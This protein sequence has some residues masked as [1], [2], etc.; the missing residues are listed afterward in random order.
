MKVQ[1][2]LK[3][4]ENLYL[5]QGYSDIH[6]RKYVIFPEYSIYMEINSC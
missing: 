6:E 2:L 3:S 5:L 4:N 1:Q